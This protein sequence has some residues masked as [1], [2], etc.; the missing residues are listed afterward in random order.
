MTTFDPDTQEQDRSVLQR[1]VDDFGGRFALDCYVVRPGRVREG[2]PF[3]SIGY[4]TL[5]RREPSVQIGHARPA[6]IPARPS[7]G[8]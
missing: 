5:D 1:I 3:E 4:W 8:S 7:A 6:W 2:D